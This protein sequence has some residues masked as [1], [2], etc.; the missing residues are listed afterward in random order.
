MTEQQRASAPAPMVENIPPELMEVTQW[1]VWRFEWRKDKWT[2]VPYTPH[3][4]NK[5]RSNAPSTWRSFRSAYSCYQERPDYFD[6]IGF[7]FA[8]DDPFVGGDIDHC[9]ID[10]VISDDALAILPPTYAEISPSG[11][12]IKFIARASGEYGRKTA[13]GELYSS[14]RFFTITGD[15]LAGHGKIT[16]CQAAVETFL[17]SLGTATREPRQG[18]A[19]SGSRAQNAA[20]IPDEEWAAGRFLLRE[21]INRLVARLRAATK[22]AVQLGYILRQDY[23]G[24]EIKWP[25]VIVRGDGSIDNSQIRSVFANGVRMRG[26]SFSEYVALFYHFYGS[27]CLEKW[28]TTQ[29]FREEA[30]TLWLRSRTP[31]ANEAP[32]PTPTPVK[33]GR[34]SDHSALLDR[35]YAALQTFRVG[36]EARLMISDLASNMG[37]SLRT[38]AT[39]IAE[40]TDDNRITKRKHGRYGGLIVSFP[41]MHNEEKTTDD[42]A[43]IEHTNGHKPEVAISAAIIS[44]PKP[45]DMHN[46]QAGIPTGNSQT[47]DPMSAEQRGEQSIPDMQNEI[48]EAPTFSPPECSETP[49]DATPEHRGGDALYIYKTSTSTNPVLPPVVSCMSEALTQN[50]VTIDEAVTEA[51]NVL[52]R[53]RTN[54]A[55]GE[56]KRWSITA[57]RVLEYIQTEYADRGWRVDAILHRY[58]RVR[59]RLRAQPF[60]E[61]RVLRREIIEKKATATRKRIESAERR[62]AS[63]PMP[64][65]R[66]HLESVARQLGGQLA[67]YGYELGRRDG[68]DDAR[69][70]QDGYTQG[71]MLD[72]LEI[73]ERERSDPPAARQVP[74]VSSLV[75]RLKMAKVRRQDG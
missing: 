63:H 42:I 10:G 43:H 33:R 3:T 27:E 53:S 28:G 1:V 52:P 71:E 60:E 44:G 50:R 41:D 55:T 69:I 22:P 36:I 7:M 24:F 66:A 54:E 12:G 47:D 46:D 40:L 61:M 23:H 65:A 68:A 48:E 17:A 25:G 5:A 34:G 57:D 30:A 8:K 37:V 74:D 16:E 26:F 58:E 4:T 70:E 6:G 62:A 21:E 49:T 11:C 73:V 39:L 14:L 45:Q 35:A 64:E 15:A 18:T 72:M 19:G 75:E 9:I 59:K 38:A 20:S 13:R 31:R 67:M 29:G 56:M 2:K 32:A 51:I